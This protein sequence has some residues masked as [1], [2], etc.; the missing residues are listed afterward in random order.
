MRKK[1][2][3]LLPA[4]ESWESFK[5]RLLTPEERRELDLRVEIITEMLRAR[6]DWA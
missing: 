1:P 6:E 5:E 2:L 3:V 4:G